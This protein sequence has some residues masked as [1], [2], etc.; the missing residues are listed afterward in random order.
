[1]A[2]VGHSIRHSNNNTR[3]LSENRNLDICLVHNSAGKVVVVSASDKL[4]FKNNDPPSSTTNQYNPWGITKDSRSR[5]LTED[6][7]NHCI[8][9]LDQGGHFLCP[10]DN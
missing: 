10:I 7:T 9:I 3:H 2:K 4:R 1:M 5:I 8:H 6:F